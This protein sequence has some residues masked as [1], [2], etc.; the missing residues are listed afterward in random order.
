MVRKRSCPEKSFQRSLLL[1]H[2]LEEKTLHLIHKNAEPP[3]MTSK[4]EKIGRIFLI[5]QSFLMQ[6]MQK[7]ALDV[8]Y[9]MFQNP[10]DPKKNLPA[11]S[12]ICNFIVF[13]SQKNFD[14]E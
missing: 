8:S 11:V 5:E 13:P 14:E 2:V 9:D 6:D 4:E 3:R 10:P 7:F 12:Q 1:G